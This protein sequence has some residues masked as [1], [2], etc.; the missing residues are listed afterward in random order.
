MRQGHEA[1]EVTLGAR[2]VRVERPWVRAADG[3]GELGLAVYRRFAARDPLSLVV[4]ERMLAGVSCR[5]YGRTGEPV[6]AEA[7][8]YSCGSVEKFG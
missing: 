4:L 1:G 8:A 7:P 3:T 5:R 2:R 6:G